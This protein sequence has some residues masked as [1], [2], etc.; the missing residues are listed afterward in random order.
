MA[1]WI[2]TEIGFLAYRLRRSL[3]ET[4]EE[5]GGRFMVTPITV[6]NWERGK[7]KKVQDI[8]VA[9]LKDLAG[10]LA[11][12]GQLIPIEAAEVRYRREAAKENE[13]ND[14]THELSIG[15]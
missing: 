3:E 9:L 14:S 10:K 12:R 5:F 11:T 4:R 15:N 1:I 6:F 2:K 13:V 8:H 7:S